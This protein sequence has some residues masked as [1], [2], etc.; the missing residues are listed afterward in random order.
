MVKTTKTTK[1]IKGPIKPNYENKR[2]YALDLS[3][4]F[5]GL[6]RWAYT[7]ESGSLENSPLQQDKR[8]RIKEQS[9]TLRFNSIIIIFR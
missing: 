9:K 5:H 8:H 3:H 1:P 2:T 7:A 6:E 4:I